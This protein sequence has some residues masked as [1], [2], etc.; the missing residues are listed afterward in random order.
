MNKRLTKREI[1]QQMQQEISQF[2]D[3]GGEVHEFERGESALINGKLDDRSSGFGQGKQK[4]TPLT[5]ELKAV[6]ERK[7][8]PAAPK[9]QKVRR[10]YKKIIYDDFGEP[11]R[12]VWVE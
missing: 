1:H 5:D 10:P 9:M 12:E 7:K 11:I 3:N 8:V 6:D 4:R 2:L